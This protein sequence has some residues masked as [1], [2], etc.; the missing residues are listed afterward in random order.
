MRNENVLRPILAFFTIILLIQCVSGVLLFAVK[1]GFT[2]ESITGFYLGNEEQFIRPKTFAGL[3]EITVPHL[4]AIGAVLF[5][6][7]HLVSLLS[8]GKSRFVNSTLY[9]CFL[10]AAANLSAGYLIRFVH[11]GFLYLK[12]LCF[13]LF[14]LAFAALILVVIQSV[15]VGPETRNCRG[16]RT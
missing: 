6:L 4:A 14:A 11:P 15:I 2:P 16:E 8:R 3:L 13:T 7:G 1:L 12:L 10:S 9:V 5:I